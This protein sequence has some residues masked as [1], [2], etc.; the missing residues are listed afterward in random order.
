MK[1]MAKELQRLKTNH[2]LSDKTI[3]YLRKNFSYLIA[4]NRGNEG[5]VRRGMEAMWRHPF[6][7]HSC[8]G[9]WCRHSQEPDAT[10][11]GLPYGKP[12]SDP[13]LQDSLKGLFTGLAAQSSKLASLESTQVNE[14]FNSMVA[15]KAPKRLFF[16]GSES[17][18]FR[19][20]S[21]V[22]Q[23]NEGHQ[24]VP[25]VTLFIYYLYSSMN[26]FVTH[27]QCGP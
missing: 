20:A 10:F 18:D 22:A 1:N 14:S 8:C 2:K 27:A 13:A 11:S 3:K 9:D 26:F 21:A 24:Y 5:G 6:N 4:Q 12:L 15:A 7:D 23:K 16:A 17:L 19:I 25:Q